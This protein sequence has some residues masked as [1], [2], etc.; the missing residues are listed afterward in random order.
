MRCKNFQQITRIE[1]LT[2]D[3]NNADATSAAHF[4]VTVFFIFL[5]WIIFPSLDIGFENIHLPRSQQIQCWHNQLFC[6]LHTSYWNLCIY[7]ILLNEQRALL[8]INTIC[9][10]SQGDP[11]ATVASLYRSQ[12]ESRSYSEEEVLREKRRRN[13]F[14]K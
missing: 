6:S 4:I 7:L 3:N 10:Y 12:F 5:F 11:V 1:C 13:I 9:Q 2:L 8:L 14:I